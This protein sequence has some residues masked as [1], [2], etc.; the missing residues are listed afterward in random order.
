MRWKLVCQ[1]RRLWT[2]KEVKKM[3]VSV[4]RFREALNVLKPA[5]A[6]NSTIKSIEYVLLK[7]GQAVATNLETMVVID[8]PEADLTTLVPFKDVAEWLKFIPGGELLHIQSEKG[9]LSLSWAEGKSTFP[10]EN[11]E[12][13]PD[14]PEFLPVVEESLNTDILIPALASVQPYAA[15]EDSRP[16]LKGVTL[17]LGNPVEVAAGDG[18]RMADKV[19]ALSF[20]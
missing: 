6:R 3:D 18:Y 10:V 5:V 19:L 4:G 11:H 9:R 16:I 17:I 2:R 1:R 12:N 8:M 14:V 20:P 15:T 7:N 13:F